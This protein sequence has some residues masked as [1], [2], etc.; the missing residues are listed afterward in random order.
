MNV[1]GR[2]FYENVQA[3]AQELA[4]EV[5]EQVLEALTAHLEG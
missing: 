5:G 1:L 2:Q 4:W 3:Q